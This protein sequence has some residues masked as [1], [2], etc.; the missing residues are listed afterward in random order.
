MRKT[1]MYNTL[2]ILG[3]YLLMQLLIWVAVLAR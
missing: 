2:L 1:I 3:Y